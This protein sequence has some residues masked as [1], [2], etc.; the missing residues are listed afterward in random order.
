MPCAAKVGKRS[1]KLSHFRTIDELAVREHAG[2][3]LID[4]LT[5]PAALCGDIDEGNRIW[6]QVLVHLTLQR[7]RSEHPLADDAARPLAGG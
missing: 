1:L 5:K 7:L 2:D 6:T 3:R 4:R